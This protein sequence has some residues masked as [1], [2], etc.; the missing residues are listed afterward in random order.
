VS[1]KKLLTG[2]GRRILQECPSLN[3]IG[4]DERTLIERLHGLGAYADY[5]RGIQELVEAGYLVQDP[6][7][8]RYKRSS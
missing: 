1:E 8:R 4:I 2:F 5:Q 6:P 3:S 7:M